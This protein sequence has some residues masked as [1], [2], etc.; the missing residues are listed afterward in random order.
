MKNVA[1]VALTV[2]V[3]AVAPGYAV[4]APELERTIAVTG[5]ATV[6]VA[7]D[8]AT[9]RFGVQD[10]RPTA[11]AAL[12]AA[13]V[14]SRRVLDRL[15]GEGIA[16]ADLTTGTIRVERTTRPAR[17]GSRRQVVEFVASTSIEAVVRRVGD[18]GR[19]AAA[20]VDAG[21]TN[22][23]GPSFSVSD[24]GEAGRQALAAAYGEA[25]RKAQ[26]LA[27]A[28]RVRLGGPIRIREGVDTSD[29]TQDVLPSTQVNEPS[30]GRPRTP[31]PTR[32]GTS[33][34]T[35]TVSVVFAVDE[36]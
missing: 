17:P 28:S 36:D 25:E 6:K 32:P 30:G 31:P 19:V 12:S 5:T 33:E 16:A 22:V 3:L 18:A 7:N 15:A 24:P 4:A 35:A 9:F 8:L 23:S 26:R 34:V 21:A 27:G 13:A 1:A 11:A 29:A 20:A 10:R 2:G 14:R